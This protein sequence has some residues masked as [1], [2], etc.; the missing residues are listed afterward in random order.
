[1]YILVNFF[2]I[3]MVQENFLV[4]LPKNN[5]DVNKVSSQ[6]T[7]FFLLKSTLYILPISLL[8][9]YLKKHMKDKYVLFGAFIVIITGALYRSNFFR[10]ETLS[11]TNFY[12]SAA[13]LIS[14]T[15]VGESA[16]ISILNKVISPTL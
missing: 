16:S 14:G 13:I 3:K 10:S 8:P 15:L 2:V 7:G 1:M 4:E 11:L 5:S 9:V 6:N 12:V